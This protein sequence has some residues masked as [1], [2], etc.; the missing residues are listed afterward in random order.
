MN[1]SV[2]VPAYNEAKTIGQTLD[3]LAAALPRSEVVVIDDGSTDGT[4]TVAA[5]RGV[6]VIKNRRNLGKAAALARGLQV[7][8]G[9]VIAMVDADMGSRA[10]EIRPLIEAVARGR[11]HMAIACFASSR[12][13]GLGLVKNLARWGIYL[14]S[15][16]RLQ[17]PLSGQRAAC[18][19]LLEQCL[20]ARGG[21]GL[22]TEL[23]LRA[24]RAGYRVAEIPTG[25]VHRGHGWQ[26]AGI[27]HR[28]RQFFQVLLALWRGGVRR[29]RVL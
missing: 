20:P 7:C 21:Y 10:G 22:E 11:C 25:F 6:L 23:T 2:L 4:G 17:A 1:I 3:S 8:S 12:G 26:P 14:C 16:V 18:R 15:G 29:W 5:A 28:G 27:K 13:G 19:P 24:L 9:E